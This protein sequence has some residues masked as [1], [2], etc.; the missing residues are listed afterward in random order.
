MLEFPHLMNSNRSTPATVVITIASILCLAALPTQKKPAPPNSAN[1]YNVQFA[2]V[3]AASGIHFHHE[4]A[5]S[6][7]KLY[8]ETMGAGAGWIDYNQDGYLDAILI[9]SGYTP[10]FHPPAAPQPALGDQDGRLTRVLRQLPAAE[11]EAL[12]LVAWEQLSYA[13]AAQVLGCSPNAI[14]I[15][16][17]RA[18]TRVREAFGEPPPEN[19]VRQTP[20][21]AHT[22]GN[23][24][25]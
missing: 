20:M 15:R 11:R 7:Q 2:D 12:M 13:E 16:V 5:A 9:N 4:R 18:R 25:R 19:P 21:P 1:P 22:G 23:H 6:D 17:H 3:T 14:G 10:F 8:L 24:G